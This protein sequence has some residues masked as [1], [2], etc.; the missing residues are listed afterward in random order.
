MGR[1]GFIG[2]YRGGMV[3]CEVDTADECWCFGP[4]MGGMEDNGGQ[5]GDKNEGSKRKG[6]EAIDLCWRGKRREQRF[7]KGKEEKLPRFMAPAPESKH[8][9]QDQP[10]ASRRSLVASRGRLSIGACCGVHQAFPAW[11]TCVRMRC[12]YQ[13]V[14]RPCLFYR[15]QVQSDGGRPARKTKPHLRRGGAMPCESRPIFTS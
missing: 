10:E 5:R 14:R 9:E 4:W 1:D 2:G 12:R 13:A 11:S 3:W 15:G 6:G 7:S 8:T